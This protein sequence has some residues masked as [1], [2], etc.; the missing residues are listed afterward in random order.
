MAKKIYINEDS[1]VDAEGADHGLTE[2]TPYKTLKAALLAHQEPDAEFFTYKAADGDK[3]AAYEPTTATQL[4]KTRK[5][6]E[7]E[8]KKAATQATKVVKEVVVAEQQPI[9]C[10]VL[11]S[12]IT[13]QKRSFKI[14]KAG[15]H[16]DEEGVQLFG[17]VHRL[18]LQKGNIFMTLRDGTGYIQVI[19][20]KKDLVNHPELRSLN[21]ESSV[22][23][24]G[25][26][27]LLP[28]GKTAP[29]GHEFV[30]DDILI[31]GKA[32]GDKEAIS[33]RID[34]EAGNAILYDQRHLVLRGERASNIMRVR[35]EIKRL[36]RKFYDEKDVVEVDPPAM[37]QT[38]AEGGAALFTFD[39]YGQPAYLTQSS[40]L[41]LESCLAALG[42]VYC[43]QESFRAEKSHT[44]RHLSEY[45]HLEA[46]FAHIEFEDLL[47][48]LEELV[49]YI[50]KEVTESPV[51]GP[52]IKE[53]NPEFVA[54]K[55]PFKRMTHA[56]A[57]EYLKEH[58]IRDSE[59]NI[60]GPDDDIGEAAERQILARMNEPIFLTEFPVH[61][62]AFYMK[63]V[64][65]NPKVTESVDLLLPG[66]GEVI[67][68]SMRIDDLEELTAAFQRE[69]IDPA[70]Y[71]WYT[72]QAK[73]GTCSH[74]GYGL[75]LERFVAYLCGLETVRDAQLY[76][77]FTDRCSP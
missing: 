56:Q 64:K 25:K 16:R 28:E 67:G 38:Q 41:Y 4:K 22:L 9:S 21:L 65:G 48:H 2:S 11:G 27:V 59:G 55:G 34:A 20:T 35:A 36:V 46:E 75:G 73:Y 72:D 44:R 71:Y 43:I 77:R 51:F 29:G 14:N 74:G 12:T 70:L 50:S 52:I 61:L 57:I 60:H 32:P 49:I 40:Q 33:N 76:P 69:G 53:L 39:Y 18:R 23:V 66:V 45:T 62:K 8:L 68:S 54:P 24:K 1:G 15:E 5:F 42:D 30:V 58:D 3:P 10:Y 7:K 26:I 17:W 6:I 13:S 31:I 63:K 37:V 47:Q 19:I